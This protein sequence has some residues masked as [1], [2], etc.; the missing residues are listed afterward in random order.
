MAATAFADTD[1]IKS[2]CLEFMQKK[3]IVNIWTL[4]P[5]D[6]HPLYQCAYQVIKAANDSFPEPPKGTTADGLTWW[7]KGYS[8]KLLAAVDSMTAWAGSTEGRTVYVVQKISDWFAKHGWE[9]LKEPLSE[10]LRRAN[11]YHDAGIA[12]KEQRKASRT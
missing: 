1:I 2:L 10:L 8:E 9:H 6:K 7:R 12:L 11:E 5:E 3:G 4:I